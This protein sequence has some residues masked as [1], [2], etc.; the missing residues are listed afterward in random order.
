[1]IFIDSNEAFKIAIEAGFLS[2]SPRAA[3][4]AGKYM[5]MGTNDFPE[6][7]SH[8]FKHIMTRKYLPVRVSK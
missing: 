7:S 6:W 4:Y 5:Y 8:Q 3:N 1:M 2:L